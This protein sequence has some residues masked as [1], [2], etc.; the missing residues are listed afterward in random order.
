MY[1]AKVINKVFDQGL[2]TINVEFTDGETTFSDHCVPQDKNAFNGWLKQK[3]E[4]LNHAEQTYKDLKDGDEL[5]VTQEQEPT[6]TP[7]PPLTKAEVDRN[8]WLKDYER[9][10][11]VKTT[12][13]DSGILTGTEAQLV[14]FKKK[15]KD[16]FLPDY[17]NYI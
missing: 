9:W 15:V 14:A 16:D 2:L 3:L 11:K 17:I 7:T 6:P 10:L 4:F 12:L 8:E 1:T 13:I 5:V